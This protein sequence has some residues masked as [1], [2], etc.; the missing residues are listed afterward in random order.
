MNILKSL[1]IIFTIILVTACNNKEKKVTQKETLETTSTPTKQ[2]TLSKSKRLLTK[3]INAHGGDLY[4]KA[5]YSFMFRGNTYQFKNE[6]F[7][8][9]YTKIYKKDKNDIKDV[10]NNGTFTRTINNKPVELSEKE[11]ASGTGA[12]NSVIYFATL[13]YKLNDAAVNSE[14]VEQTT[15][16]GELYDVIEVTFSQEG[17]GED[18]DDQ[19]YYWINSTTNKI[20]YLAYNYSVNKGG[21]RFRSANNKRIVDGIT[22]QDY[23]NYEAPVGTPLKNLPALYETNKLKELSKIDTENVVNL[24]LN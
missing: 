14:Y 5:H 3:A 24:S 21:V 1:L 9:E 7:N 2:P 17:G 8:Y 11:I 10:L 6:G 4:Q 16:K 12:I 18:H 19:Y 22:F 20:D 13:P 15:I 23:V